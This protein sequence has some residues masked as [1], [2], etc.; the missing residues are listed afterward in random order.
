MHEV[1]R[2]FIHYIYSITG[3][4]PIP[5]NR[6]NKLG[7]LIENQLTSPPPDYNP[8]NDDGNISIRLPFY[9][10]VDVTSRNYLSRR[11]KAAVCRRLKDDFDV[12]FIGYMQRRYK[13]RNRINRKVYIIELIEDFC[14]EYRITMTGE[15]IDMLKKKYYRYIEP[16]TPRRQKKVSPI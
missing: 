12:C 16:M 8:R 13:E 7:T 5:T 14:Q 4:E 11:A 2:D 9:A 6:L 1:Y 10:S 3:Q 15:N